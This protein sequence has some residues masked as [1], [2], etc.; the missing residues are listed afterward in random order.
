MNSIQLTF[1]NNSNDMNNSEIVVF[2]GTPD[3]NEKGGGS[4]V[5]WRVIKNCGKGWSHPFTYS[6]Q[7]FVGATDPYGNISSPILSQMMQ[8]WSIQQS[9][10]G[11]ALVLDTA[12]PAGPG[13]VGI[14]NGMSTGAVDA[15]VYRDGNLIAIKQGLAPGQLATFAFTPNITFGIMSQAPQEGSIIHPAVLSNIEMTMFGLEGIVKAE[16]VMSGGGQAGPFVF[17]LENAE[18]A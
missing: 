12:N 9:P 3:S 16:I 5:A 7:I 15:R 18:Y 17:T 14:Y 2:Q 4:K 10:S 8:R 6:P 13:T 11:S 1:I